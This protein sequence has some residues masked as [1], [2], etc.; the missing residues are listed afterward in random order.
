MSS[1][2]SITAARR[3]RRSGERVERQAQHLAGQPA[4]LRQVEIGFELRLVIQIDRRA[5]DVAGVIGDAFQDGRD[6]DRRDD[7]P[8]VA[9]LRR[10][11]GKQLDAE[12]IGLQLQRVDAVVVSQHLLR[13][14]PC[15]A[16]STPAWHGQWRSR[17]RRPSTA[18]DRAVHLMPI[19]ANSAYSHLEINVAHP[20]LSEIAARPHDYR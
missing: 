3:W 20:P 9:R 6:L 13:Q 19:P 2:R 15:R 1:S 14:S 16:L 10:M 11:D 7:Q 8:Q 12:P 18:H 5:G 17:L 4:H